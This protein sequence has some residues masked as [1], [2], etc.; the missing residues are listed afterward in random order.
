MSDA[1]RHRDQLTDEVIRHAS[2]C[3]SA[4]ALVVYHEGTDSSGDRA[5]L[6][7][8][9]PGCEACRSA[10]EYLSS[11]AAAE[12][13]EPSDLPPAVAERL[14]ATLAAATRDT[15][16]VHRPAWMKL[17]AGLLLAAS[18]ALAGYVWWPSGGFDEDLGPL[19]SDGTLQAMEPAG[20]MNTV[21]VRFRWTAH[22]LAASYSV[23][24]FDDEMREIW[25]AQTS[26]DATELAPDAVARR[27][28]AGGGRFSW[29]VIARDG[30]GFGFDRS[31]IGHFEIDAAR[32]RE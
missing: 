31:P 12:P 10:L 2:G 3:P 14:E 25:E 5:A 23:I 4:D 9:L 28:L 30:T 32:S 11:D 13:A 26:G 17:A 18:L 16:P 21:P 6:E 29:Q 15:G 20:H 24:L 19:R 7:A 8:H 27:L 22:P 1:T